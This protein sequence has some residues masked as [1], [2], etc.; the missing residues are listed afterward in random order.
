VTVPAGTTVSTFTTSMP[1]SKGDRIGLDDDHLAGSNFGDAG[2]SSGS[3]DIFQPIPANGTMR[4]P[5]FSGGGELLFNADVVPTALF[6]KPKK[7]KKTKSGVAILVV[8]APNPG[9][10]SVSAK[11][12]FIK[13]VSKTVSAAGNVKLKLRPTKSTRSVLRRFGQANGQI[14][15]TF[16]PTGG[17]PSSQ[18]LK[19]RL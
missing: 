6:P 4:N 15:V 7:P 5:D 11:R 14:N 9:V 3:E 1:I 10:L 17:S 8:V 12:A 19:V 2:G 18:Q 13:S 16:T